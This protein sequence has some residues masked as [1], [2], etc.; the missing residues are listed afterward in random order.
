M[1]KAIV[2]F[3]VLLVLWIT[4]GAYCYVCNIRNDCRAVP[5]ASESEMGNQKPDTVSSAIAKA[6]IPQILNLYFDFNGKMVLLS[7]EDKK[8]IDEL[9]KYVIENPGTM[10]AI[11]G[12]SD[13]VGS[14]Q[15][16]L[17]ISTARA[18]FAC[19]QLI[20]AGID[21]ARINVTGM[22]DSEPVNSENT[23]EGNAKNRRAQIQIK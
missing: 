18:Q 11:T 22:S 6:A 19:E 14:Q 2:L 21:T 7:G 13:R 8:Q 15:A 5:A 9:K 23:P 1:K 12:H 20:A 3:T 17:K 4:G 16:K 10:I